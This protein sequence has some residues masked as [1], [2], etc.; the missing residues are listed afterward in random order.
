M[1]VTSA[2]TP[3]RLCSSTKTMSRWDAHLWTQSL[4]SCA[5]KFMK[6]IS[7]APEVL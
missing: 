4:A 2:L 6:I 5:K 7:L 3:T 1:E